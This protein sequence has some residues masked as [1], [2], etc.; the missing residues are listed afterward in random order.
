MFLADWMESLR[1]VREK[2]LGPLAAVFRDRKEERTAERSLAT[3]VLA[4]YGA[5]R[6]ETLADLLMDAD[7][8][9][10]TVLFP[11]VEANLRPGRG[12]AERDRG[13]EAGCGENG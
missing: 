9:Q 11:R 1:P 7:D 8:K 3:S 6:P 4:N 13:E 12:A 2:L 5:G 10:F